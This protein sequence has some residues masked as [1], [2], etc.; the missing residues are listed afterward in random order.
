MPSEAKSTSFTPI[1]F[2]ISTNKLADSSLSSATKIRALARGTVTFGGIALVSALDFELK[3]ADEGL[4]LVVGGGLLGFTLFSLV[5]ALS[6]SFNASRF[7]VL[8]LLVVLL[9]SSV[10][11][12]HALRDVNV[13]MI[14]LDSCGVNTILTF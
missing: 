10:F 1:S 9:S 2:S 11:L 5:M 13:E 7:S 14:I 12:I 6:S 8:A 4:C 3:T